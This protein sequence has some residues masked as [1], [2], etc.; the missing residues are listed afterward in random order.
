V[1]HLTGEW[2][3]AAEA[4][5][6]PNVLAKAVYLASGYDG[7]LDFNPCGPHGESPDKW[8]AAVLDDMRRLAKAEARG[9]PVSF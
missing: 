9:E 7:P 3:R 5:Y 2:A 1:V 8:N 6:S 4:G